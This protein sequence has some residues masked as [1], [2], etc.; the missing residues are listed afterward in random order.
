MTIRNNQA[1]KNENISQQKASVNVKQSIGSTSSPLIN[2]SVDALKIGDCIA[3]YA[4]V[5]GASG[6]FGYLSIDGINM[7]CSE[8]I[9]G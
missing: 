4:D 1:P 8:L 2:N 5:S 6:A 3:L 7:T 9:Q